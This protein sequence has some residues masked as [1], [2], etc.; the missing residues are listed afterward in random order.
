MG[1]LACEA[2]KR[3]VNGV[4]LPTITVT[5]TPSDSGMG[6]L[7]GPPPSS[8]HSSTG[9]FRPPVSIPPASPSDGILDKED[10]NKTTNN[11]IVISDGRKVQQEV[12]FIDHKS[13]MPLTFVRYYDSRREGN[14]DFAGKWRHSFDYQLLKNDTTNVLVRYLPNGDISKTNTSLGSL[15]YDQAAKIWKVVLYEGSSEYYSNDGVL[16]GKLLKKL[17][18]NGIGWTLNYDHSGKLTM[19]THTNGQTVQISWS[20]NQINQVI[21]PAGNIYRYGYNDNRLTEVSY[22]SG[23]GSRSYHYG[24]NGAAFQ[25]L[26]GISVNGNRYNTYHFSGDK[27][28]QSGRDDGTQVDKLEYGNNYTLL[29]N[30]MGA[31]LKYFYSL[32]QGEKKLTKLERSG[33]SHCPNSSQETI[34]DANGFIRSEK[35]WNG[36]STEYTR[37]NYGRITLER[38][39]VVVRTE[40]ER[41]SYEWSAN[42]PS[43]L[44]KVSRTVSLTL[45]RKDPFGENVRVNVP[46]SYTQYEYYNPADANG[47]GRLKSVKSC[48]IN[49]T[50]AGGER[51]YVNTY[52]YAFH[53]NGML[54]NMT[55]SKNGKLTSYSYDAVGNL[56]QVKNAL[57][58]IM[59][60]S[61]YDAL[62]NVGKV[63]DTN[64]RNFLYVYDS[65][66][67]MI[68]ESEEI[69][70]NV[71]L[72]TYYE[73]GPFGTT[74]TTFPNGMVETTNYNNNGTIASISHSSSGGII[75]QQNYSYSN[76]GVLQRIEYRE[77]NSIRYSRF[78]EQNQLGWITADKGNNGQNVS[79]EYDGNGNVI[80]ET[81]ALGQTKSYV[82]DKLGR[83]WRETLPDGSVISSVWGAMGN[84]E[85]VTDAAGNKTTYTYNGLGELLTEDS[86]ATGKTSYSY[87]ADGNLATLTRT[88]GSV[89]NY[90]YDALNRRTKA[91]TGEQ[92]QVWHYDN[93]TNG[94]GRL[95]A[96]SDGIT[97]K[98]Y[99]YTKS[100][101]LTAQVTK[102]DGTEYNYYWLYDAYDRLIQEGVGLNDWKTIYEYDGLNRISTVKFKIGDDIKTVVSDIRYE[103]YGGVKSWNYGNGLSRQISYDQDYRLTGILASGIQN[104]SHSYNANNWITQINNGLDSNKTTKYT[105][106]AL[107]RLNIAS[108]NQY[109]ESWQND[110]NYNRT[111]RTGHTNAVTNYVLGQGNRLNSTTGAE[112]KSFTYDILGNLTKK[113]GYGGNVDYTYDAFNL[114]KTVK[115]GSATTTYDYDVFKLR[116]RKSGSGGTVNYVYAPDGRILAESP[117]ST[118]QNGS[119]AKIYIWLGD[120]PIAVVSNNQLYY[121]H[122]D[123]LGRPEVITGANQAVVWKAQTSSY[124]SAVVQ[125]SIGDFN[126][127]FPGQYYDTESSLWYNWNRYYDASIG[128][129][130]QSDPIGLAGGLNTYAYVEN[131]PINF[132][133]EDGLERK[134]VNLGKGYIGG[135]DTYNYQGNSSFEIHVFKGDPR[136]GGIEKGMYGPDGW[137]NKHGKI[138][139]PD[140]IPNSVENQCKGQA[141]DVGRRMGLIPDKG[142]ANIKGDRWKNFLRGSPFIGPLI[143]LTKPSPERACDIDPTQPYCF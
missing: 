89:T 112:A 125:S 30:P 25:I 120:Q 46:T 53:A 72:R 105:Y 59:L 11:P 56:T 141:I 7:N 62:G 23:I 49:A 119:L 121:I 129:Y 104:L 54:Q 73:Y 108:S 116:S 40:A 50:Q 86:P 31:Q 16:K 134:Y 55:I 85:S 83:L 65:R 3:P 111:S 114:L 71:F 34:Y 138:G 75:S 22:P 44:M 28:I 32:I 13:D 128:R 66:G 109:K 9:G 124:D 137:F 52:G 93:C 64:G 39:G 142:N 126:L 102:I 6:H 133:D 26:S 136:S 107:G 37:D 43:R 21:D 118:S 84:L 38:V 41:I 5:A 19:V 70:Q 113:T 88:N 61:N 4:A 14:S 143:E 36:D 131:N 2:G 77:G 10:C 123:H 115:T 140:G 76:L 80:K 101:Q 98:G 127:G 67:Q 99:G 79:Q 81:N 74:K 110:T 48:G 63:T 130:T 122:N 29:T 97:G 24:E 27:A 42:A 139:R 87:D 60:Y 103:P 68:E 117:L 47:K 20:S 94:I 45:P 33:V 1:V 58:Q 132:V 51:C 15:T 12:D 78:N 100:G 90:I 57:G 96:T 8:G 92:V 18:P 135:I 17:D 82:Y 69:N 95:C 91:Q 106:D 35:N